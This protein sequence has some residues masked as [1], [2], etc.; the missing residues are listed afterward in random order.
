MVPSVRFSCTRSLYV[1]AFSAS[2]QYIDEV[3]NSVTRQHH[4]Y[5]SYIVF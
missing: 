3:I 5:Y 4:Y 1:R 2:L